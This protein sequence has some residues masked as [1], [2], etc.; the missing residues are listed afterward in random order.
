MS[1][2][3]KD[4]KS[5]L[6]YGGARANLFEVQMGYPPG[7]NISGQ[8]IELNEFSRRLK[9]LC[10][11]ATIPES[12]ITPVMVPFQGREIYT[13]GFKTF[14]PLTITIINDED[15]YVRAA[16]ETW[17]GAINGHN[18]NTKNSG[19][20]TSPS[21][22]QVDGLVKQYSQSAL[23][24]TPENRYKLDEVEPSAIRT[25]KFVNM[26]PI[27]VSSIEVNWNKNEIEEF[28]VTFRYDY[29]VIAP[30]E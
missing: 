10:K 22:Y 27:T 5:N 7:L 9:F 30:N 12:S 4:F 28:S 6:R 11:I 14:E 2:N 25:Y 13:A 20:N 26:F 19:I 23:L 24:P 3:I 15:F 1:F 16:F 8:D 21:S 29:W 17:I 18:S